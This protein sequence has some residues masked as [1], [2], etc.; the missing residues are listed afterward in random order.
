MYIELNK[1]VDAVNEHFKKNEDPR[2]YQFWA[3]CDFNLSEG[4]E[5][6]ITVKKNGESTYLDS[7]GETGDDPDWASDD[8]VEQVEIAKAYGFE[9]CTLNVLDPL[10]VVVARSSWDRI[11]SFDNLAEARTYLQ[12][13]VSEDI[14]LDE[15]EGKEISETAEYEKFYQIVY[16]LS[17]SGLMETFRD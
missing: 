17:S 5:L 14:D 9:F 2:D 12:E 10:Y 11:E 15:K 13:S 8:A 3:E 16:Q 1:M 7:N 6:V 4:Q